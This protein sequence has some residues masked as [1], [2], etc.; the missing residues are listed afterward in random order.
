[1]RAYPNIIKCADCG[2]EISPRN[3]H[4][5]SGKAYGCSCYKKQLAILYKKWEDEKNEEYSIKCF[6]AMQIFQNKKKSSFHDS[7]CRQWNDCR[8][9]TAKQLN[10]IINGFN[11]KEK[12]DFYIIWCSMTKDESLKRSIA[13]WVQ[14]LIRNGYQD[15]IDNELFISCMLCGRE[16]KKYGFHFLHDIEDEPELV[17]IMANGKDDKTLKENAQDEYFEILKVVRVAA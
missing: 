10:C 8:K 6:S 3:A 12:I 1:M 16:Y 13:S 17:F 5:I 4:Y 2:R 11:D 15:Y 9:L 14:S 7:I